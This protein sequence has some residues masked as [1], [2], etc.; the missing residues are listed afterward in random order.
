MEFMVTI[1]ETRLFT[2]LGGQ[3]FHRL[4]VEIVIQMQ[5]IQI[6]TMNQQIE[7]IITLTTNL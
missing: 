3:C 7:H 4:Q 1:S 6:L 5:I 2:L